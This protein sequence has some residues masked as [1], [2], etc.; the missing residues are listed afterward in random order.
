MSSDTIILP[1][2]SKKLIIA[3]DNKKESFISDEGSLDL[4]EIISWI[5]NYF[6]AFHKI[7]I[8]NFKNNYYSSFAYFLNDDRY[9]FNLIL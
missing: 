9:N 5:N 3:L 6:K 1:L 4:N 2:N 8:N 7:V